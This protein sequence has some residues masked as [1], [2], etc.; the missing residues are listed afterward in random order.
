MAPGSW[1]YEA[2]NVAADPGN[3]L[4]RQTFCEKARDQYGGKGE[5]FSLVRRS[6]LD[7]STVRSADLWDKLLP[8]LSGID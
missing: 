1:A 5:I 3:G 7:F 2:G 4:D 6:R 8:E